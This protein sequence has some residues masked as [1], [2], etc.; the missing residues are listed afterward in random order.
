MRIVRAPKASGYADYREVWRGH[1][2]VGEPLADSG[3]LEHDNV[4]S[5][6]VLVA[7]EDGNS[8]RRD[9]VVLDFQLPVPVLNTTCSMP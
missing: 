1:G 9:V 2:L 5:L 8:L 6:L 4:L 3:R 7:Q